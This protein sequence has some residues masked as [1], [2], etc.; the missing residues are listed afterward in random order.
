MSTD[1][2]TTTPGE[3]ECDRE[4]FY[5]TFVQAVEDHDSIIEFLEDL[6]IDYEN[7]PKMRGSI[8]RILANVCGCLM[9]TLVAATR[10]GRSAVEVQDK[11]VDVGIVPYARWG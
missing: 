8:N 10:S 9:Q 11:C 4:N 7:H 2:D 1:T 6:V 3:F 5:K